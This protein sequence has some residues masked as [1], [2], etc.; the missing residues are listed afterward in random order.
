MIVR[1]ILSAV[2]AYLLGSVSTGILLSRKEGLDIRKSGS[3]N[4]GASNVLRVL[5][6]RDGIL[7]FLGDGVKAVIAVLIGRWLA[8][9]EGALL[10]GLFVVIGHNWPVFFAFAG[11]KGIACSTA[12]ILMAFPWQGAVAVL[13]CL[14]VI[15]ATRYI[16]LGSLTML[17]AFALLLLLTAPFLWAGAWAILLFLLALWRHRENIK[18]LLD[19]TENKLGRKADKQA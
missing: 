18:R 10:G 13:A 4:T 1:C 16:S 17:C 8:G 15:Y 5:G 3:H 11:G 7:T 14:I 6:L 9:G 2:I 19:G 12:V